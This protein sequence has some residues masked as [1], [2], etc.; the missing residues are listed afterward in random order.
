MGFC[1][2]IT[3]N[4]LSSSA[5][6][7]TTTDYTYTVSQYSCPQNN[8]CQ[9]W[10]TVAGDCGSKNPTPTT[11][12]ASPSTLLNE[13]LTK[14]DGDSLD[15]TSLGVIGYGVY[16]YDYMIDDPDN[17]PVLLQAAHDHPE[18][19]E[20]LI[21]NRVEGTCSVTITQAGWDSTAEWEY[22][23]V[24]TDSTSD[25]VTSLVTT[26]M[27]IVLLDGSGNTVAIYQIDSVD[28]SDTLSISAGYA[29]EPPITE[30]SY[31]FIVD[32]KRISWEEYLGLF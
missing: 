4:I 18:F 20:S 7:G 11:A 30:D 5:V 25:F 26:S 17:I 28:D 9:V 15:M 21:V 32:K 1:P 12:G 3:S 8:T 14:I 2:Y 23:I 29:D 16:G 22:E 31:P 10:D 27:Y 19:D 13:F 24:A 6:D